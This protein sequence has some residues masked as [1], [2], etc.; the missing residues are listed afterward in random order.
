[1]L[2]GV[3]IDATE[4]AAEL[5]DCDTPLIG[6]STVCARVSPI[7]LPARL[8]LLFGVPTLSMENVT[9]ES[10]DRRDFPDCGLSYMSV[11]CMTVSSTTLPASLLDVPTLSKETITESVL[12]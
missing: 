2:L 3:P 9:D 5:L 12:E 8:D 4:N 10:K 6:R 11:I 7:A 1:M